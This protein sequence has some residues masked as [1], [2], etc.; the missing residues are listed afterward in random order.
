MLDMEILRP[1]TGSRGKVQE[2]MNN[3]PQIKVNVQT[4]T[5]S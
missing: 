1:P 3:Y 5:Q 4:Y 2:K